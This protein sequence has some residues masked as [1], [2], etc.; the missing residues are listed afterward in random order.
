MNVSDKIIELSKQGKTAKEIHAALPDTSLSYIYKIRSVAGKKEPSIL[1]TELQKNIKR[2]SRKNKPSQI[3]KK[4]GCSEQYVYK[5]LKGTNKQPLPFVNKYSEQDEYYT[6]LYAV[7]PIEKYLKRRSVVWCPFDKEESL[8]VRYLRS[9]GHTVFYTHI[10]MGYDF[11]DTSPPERCDYIISNPPY[12]IKTEVFK[13]LNELGIPYAMLVGSAGIFAAKARFEVFKDGIEQM[14]FSS[15]IAF[16]TDYYS[17]ELKAFPPFESSY[18][19]RGVLPKQLIF[20]DLNKN[21]ITLE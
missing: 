5:V 12:S 9:Q 21:L 16:M 17:C 10:D 1:S 18:I 15:R 20:E 8:F 2:L 7:I 11:F 19:C 14:V 6:P 3:S 4:L 13:K